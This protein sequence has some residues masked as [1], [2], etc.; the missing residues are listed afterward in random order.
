[1][2]RKCNGAKFWNQVVIS[3][4]DTDIDHRRAF[5]GFLLCLQKP[6]LSVPSRTLTK[7]IQRLFFQVHRHYSWMII[8]LTINYY[9]G[10]HWHNF[11]IFLF[12]NP[13]PHLATAVSVVFCLE[14]KCPHV[15]LGRHRHQRHQP[16]RFKQ[17]WVRW[18]TGDQI[19]GR[20]AGL[21]LQE[22]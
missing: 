7:Y 17:S 9:Y 21:H 16:C 5:F 1:M 13:I 11:Y 10:Y 3:I 19:K 12:A 15:A 4:S 14:I 22:D 6:S 20:W 18:K 8:I 2:S